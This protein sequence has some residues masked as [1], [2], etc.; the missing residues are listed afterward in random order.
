M[1][2]IRRKS[3]RRVALPEV[4]ALYW[5]GEPPPNREGTP[6]EA[7]LISDAYFFGE[8]QPET[9]P[10]PGESWRHP[11]TEA[12]WAWEDAVGASPRSV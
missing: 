7:T 9:W 2:T 4:L 1:T 6:E 11:H 3:R 5:A 8:G 12:W 10:W